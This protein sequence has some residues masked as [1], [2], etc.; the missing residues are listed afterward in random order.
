VQS[1][2]KL[3]QKKTLIHKK[4]VS[5]VCLTIDNQFLISGDISGLIYIWN[6]EKIHAHD[7]AQ[8]GLM[9]TYEIHKDK[10]QI[11]NLIAIHRPLSLF[12]LTA[13]MKSFEVP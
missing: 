7:D 10:G 1:A 9:S 11:T 5:A 13:N 8:H 3:K 2:S 6:V 12:G 4:R